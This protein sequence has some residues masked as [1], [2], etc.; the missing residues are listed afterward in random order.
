MYYK[1]M[2]AIGLHVRMH[3][4]KRLFTFYHELTHVLDGHIYNEC[5]CCHDSE[6]FS[7]GLKSKVISGEEKIAN[8]VSAN[9]VIPDSEIL[10][11][12]VFGCESYRQ[13]REMQEDLRKHKRFLEQQRFSM[14]DA[15]S[16]AKYQDAQREIRRYSEIIT[17][18]EVS[19]DQ[20]GFC[21]TFLEL[22]AAT[23]YPERILKYKLE[24]MRI[25]GFDIDAQELER[26]DKMFKEVI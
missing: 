11:N 4:L 18:L 26:Y 5:G 13:Y 8:L 6:I 24:A 9:T 10:D 3:M 21:K 14:S 23:G 20:T 22:S 2:P 25:R 1:I 15:W 12:T 7:H 17:D 16:K 19:L